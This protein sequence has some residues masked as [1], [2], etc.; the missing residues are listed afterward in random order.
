[1]VIALSLMRFE[2]SPTTGHDRKFGCEFSIMIRGFW[3]N[4]SG[5][6]IWETFHVDNANLWMISDSDSAK[7][8]HVCWIRR[9]FGMPRKHHPLIM[10]WILLRYRLPSPYIKHFPDLAT[11]D[12]E[13]HNS[14]GRRRIYIRIDRDS[15][16]RRSCQPQQIN[17]H[18]TGSRLHQ[19]PW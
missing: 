18:V 16:N 12:E 15:S 6:I 5:W 7:S 4:F 13:V 14:R 11:A 3:D 17:H 1:M 2:D 19:I 10:N 9:A 8:H